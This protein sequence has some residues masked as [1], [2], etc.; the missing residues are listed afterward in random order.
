MEQKTML[1]ILDETVKYYS[2]DTSRR[3]FSNVGICEYLTRDGKMCGVG[4]CMKNP[5]IKMR[6]A[7]TEMMLYGY[8]GSGRIISLE[9]ELKPEYKGHPINFWVSIQIL[10][11]GAEHWNASGLTP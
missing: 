3:G 5:T 7:V 4:R 9:D 8:T 6:G 1:E 2:E 10:H 11:D